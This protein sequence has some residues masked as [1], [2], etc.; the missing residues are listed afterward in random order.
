MNPLAPEIPTEP[1]SSR[2]PTTNLI[3][4]AVGLLDGHACRGLSRRPRKLGDVYGSVT[5]PFLDS[6][7][8][9]S[10]KYSSTGRLFH[11]T[12]TLAFASRLMLRPTMTC[13]VMAA[14]WS[15]TGTILLPEMAV[16][17]P[18]CNGGAE[19]V[20]HGVPMLS[21]TPY[22]FDIRD[23]D[24]ITYSCSCICHACYAPGFKP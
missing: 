4:Y 11:T 8:S 13:T 3:S 9:G 6:P 24:S 1:R 7:S 17:K 18:W 22:H 16:Q 10:Q 21:I 23:D 20:C 2:P 19:A 15:R 12:S 5:A 14:I